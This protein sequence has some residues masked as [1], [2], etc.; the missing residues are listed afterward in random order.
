MEPDAAA[1][2]MQTA[3]AFIE[4]IAHWAAGR[5]D[6]EA[7]ALVGSWARGTARPDSDV[8]IVI[9]TTQPEAYLGD[10]AW[11]HT[12]GEVESVSLEDWGLV[13]ARRVFYAGGLEAEIGITTRAWART[14]P[15]DA[16][17]GLVLRGGI[18]ALADR[19]GLLRALV[20]AV[21]KQR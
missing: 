15:V 14:D 10:Q 4:A 3:E 2:L 6:I 11:L 18:R 7:A 20:E 12:F 5:E 16:G 1:A 13:Q 17:T 9:L 8:D 21:D 19:H